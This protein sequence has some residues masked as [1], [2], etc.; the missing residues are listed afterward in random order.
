M[1]KFAYPILTHPITA[2]ICP[3]APP[4]MEGLEND[5]TGWVK[6]GVIALIGLCVLVSIGAMVMGRIFRMH[7]VSQAGVIGL[8]LSVVAAILY[9]AFPGVVAGIIGSGC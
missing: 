6:W 4:G 8:V 7:H 9:V 5:V 3:K 2:A 1:L